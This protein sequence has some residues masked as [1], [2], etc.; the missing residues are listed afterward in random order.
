MAAQRRDQDHTGAKVSYTGFRGEEGAKNVVQ[1]DGGDAREG[2][3]L[4]HNGRR[5]GDTGQHREEVRRDNRGRE[6]PVQVAEG[7]CALLGQLCYSPWKEAC[8]ST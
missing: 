5:D 6:H 3:E 8:T 1:Y 4:R 7:G 2:A